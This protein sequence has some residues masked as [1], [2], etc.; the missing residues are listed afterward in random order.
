MLKFDNLFFSSIICE[1]RLPTS[2]AAHVVL[3]LSLGLAVE[4]F[5]SG[6]GSKAPHKPIKGQDIGFLLAALARALDRESTYEVA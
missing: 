1:K 6:E 5:L 4:S 3:F 2:F